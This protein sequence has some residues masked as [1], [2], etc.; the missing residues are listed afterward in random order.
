MKSFEGQTFRADL[1]DPGREYADLS[2]VGCTFQNCGLSL[3]ADAG[4]ENRIR[5][6][7]VTLQD[8]VDINS[9]IGP[10]HF[11]DVVVN[12]LW[13]KGDLL[14]LWGPLFERV[15][16][17]GKL[18]QIKLNRTASSAGI[19]PSSDIRVI[20]RWHAER[21]ARLAALNAQREEHYARVDWALDITDAQPSL[22]ELEGIPGDKLR[23]NP[24]TQCVVSRKLLVKSKFKMTLLK[25]APGG[26][27][28]PIEE[29]LE[30]PDAGDEAV[31]VA[32]TGQKKARYK[33]YVDAIAMFRKLGV[34]SA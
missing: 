29:L 7:N 8:C 16:L 14:I 33:P 3:G 12:G 20:E 4:P 13:T 30:E 15:T 28:V 1:R 2:F 19:A 9:D 34:T 25:G 27:T 11:V 26:L 17:R 32:P 24:E 5:V 31:L 10:A 6:R 18:G 21:T 22:L 23:L